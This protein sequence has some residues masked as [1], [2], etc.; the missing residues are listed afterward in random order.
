MD[1]TDLVRLDA[2][3]QADLVRQG[4]VTPVELVEAAIEAVEAVDPQLGAV[5]IRTPEHA[6]DH[7]RT[8]SKD[9]PFPGVPILVK[10]M[11]L[12]LA[13]YPYGHGG[14][15]LMRDRGYV[16]DRTTYLAAGLRDAGFAFLGRSTS[17]L[18]GVELGVH[19]L[20]LHTM[21]RNPWN[22]DYATGG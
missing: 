22:T 10:D 20:D 2:T 15:R 3:A 18:Q 16:S 9:A 21:P 19:D 1:S 12:E 5:F 17:A 4:E 7:A 13:G 8:V 14:L 11:A 6:L